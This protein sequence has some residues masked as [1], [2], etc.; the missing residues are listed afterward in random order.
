M[1]WA[2]SRRLPLVFAMGGGYGHD[3]EATLQVQVNTY[4][5]ALA[6][7]RRWQG[8]ALAAEVAATPQGTHW[9]NPAP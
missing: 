3:M 6:F 5:T 7:E 9:H 2:W 1:D 8:Q 4:R